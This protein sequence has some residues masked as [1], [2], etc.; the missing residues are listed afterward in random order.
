MSVLGLRRLRSERPDSAAFQAPDTAYTVRLITETSDFAGIR[1]SWNDVATLSRLAKPFAWHEW[2]DAAWQWRQQTAR[3][4][5]L[6]LFDNRKLTAV[7]PLALE[8]ISKW[9]IRRRELSFLTVPDTQACDLLVAE[10]DK[11]AAA[12][13]FAAELV[14]RQNEWDVI[15]LKYLVP[16][17]IAST[18]FRDALVKLGL[19]TRLQQAPGN[20]FVSLD[21][22]WEAFYATRSR[23]LKKANNLAAN[24]LKKAGT[25]TI[26]R[27]APGTGEPADL[28]R[29]LDRAVNISARSWK[30][31]TGNSLNNAGPESFIRRLSH[32]AHERHWLSIWTLSVNDR[33]LA[34][35]YQLVADARIYALRSDFDAE[36]AEIS[37]GTYLNRCLLE[38]LFGVGLDRYYMGPGDNTYKHRWTD[39]VEPVEALTVYGRSVV[40]RWL[41]AWETSLKPRARTLRDRLRAAASNDAVRTNR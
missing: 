3:L 31:R 20:P 35:E 30:T 18:T 41:A 14:R 19:A 28:E 29:F 37:P 40:G 33:P 17:A 25:V 1:I 34:M 10:P 24:R 27:L 38:Q 12:K 36:S 13:A 15:R 23:R 39:D 6:C 32:H 2:F 9:G 16:G 21:S 11:A 7:L 22:T 4:Y 26:E 8:E 5:L